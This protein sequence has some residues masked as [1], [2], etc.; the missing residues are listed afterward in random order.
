MDLQPDRDDSFD[1]Q[2]NIEADFKPLR[3]SVPVESLHS[4]DFGAVRA[5][6]GTGSGC[7]Q[8]SSGIDS[9]TSTHQTSTDFGTKKSESHTDFGRDKSGS[10]GKEGAATLLPRIAEGEWC[11]TNPDT[12]GHH[13]VCET[14]ADYTDAGNASTELPRQTKKIQMSQKA[15]D[16]LRE[17]P[18]NVTSL[19]AIH[20]I[21]R[22]LLFRRGILWRPKQI[23][24]SKPTEFGTYT[25]RRLRYGLRHMLSHPEVITQSIDW[26][27]PRYQAD[28]RRCAH[29]DF[30][31]HTCAQSQGVSQQPSSSGILNHELDH[32]TDGNMCPHCLVV[33]RV[34]KTFR[35]HASFCY[36]LG[37]LST[38]IPPMITRFREDYPILPMRCTVESCEYHHHI[39]AIWQTH[40]ILHMWAKR[41]KIPFFHAR[42]IYLGPLHEWKYDHQ[43]DFL[44]PPPRILHALVTAVRGLRRL[45]PDQTFTLDF[46]YQ[47]FGTETPATITG[48]YP[49]LFHSVE[50]LEKL[51]D[52]PHLTLINLTDEQ[53]D[54]VIQQGRK[55]TPSEVSEASE[56]ITYAEIPQDKLDGSDEMKRLRKNTMQVTVEKVKRRTKGGSG[57]TPQN[58]RRKI[59]EVVRASEQDE[60]EGERRT[61]TLGKAK[62]VP[63]VKH[64]PT[65]QDSSKSQ[66]P[67]V[68]GTRTV[69]VKESGDLQTD[70]LKRP[71]FDASPSTNIE[72]VKRNRP[73]TPSQR[74]PPKV[75]TRC[76]KSPT[77]RVSATPLLEA[78]LTSDVI[79]RSGENKLGRITES[80]GSLVMSINNNVAKR[81]VNADFGMT[82]GSVSASDADSGTLAAG[83]NERVSSKESEKP[84]S[85]ITSTPKNTSEMKRKL[86]ASS[87]CPTQA[88][89]DNS[90][91]ASDS[92]TS[93]S[94]IVVS[95][96][97]SLLDKIPEE[98]S[99]PASS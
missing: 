65:I 93:T 26:S 6:E 71:R 25:Q 37:S 14:V 45:D 52:Y 20:V 16:R 66:S 94:S 30:K 76:A 43:H 35:E 24:P 7:A 96:A 67:G 32:Y 13:R 50:D 12:G 18:H 68:R 97:R 56:W 79:H 40:N 83:A 99:R 90:R 28:C 4:A 49:D 9:E 81:P 70:T 48:R 77:S 89:G 39:Y 58:K 2:L 5:K 27:H 3:A 53:I 8:P 33:F 34:E 55:L 60:E 74:C 47:Y 17:E 95:L 10:S 92:E 88:D 59:A 22:A 29:T 80:A 78:M 69:K 82:G 42:P 62:P 11:R 84:A 23:E 57:S 73:S 86:I 36:A 72:I 41:M 75:I 21:T 46:R 64:A 44:M 87:P 51:G 38:M 54:E 31:A 15:K 85:P 63:C 98:S 19:W 61:V 1:R 91:A